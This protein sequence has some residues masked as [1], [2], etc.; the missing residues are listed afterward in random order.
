MTDEALFEFRPQAGFRLE[1]SLT[2]TGYADEDDNLDGDFDLM[3][4]LTDIEATMEN[5]EGEYP[6]HSNASLV[7]VRGGFGWREFHWSNEKVHRYEWIDCVF[8]SRCRRCESPDNNIFMVTDEVWRESGLDGWVCFRCV[9][10][11]LGRELVPTDFK[12]VPCNDPTCMR[13]VPELR[14]RMGHD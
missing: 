11:S 10:D 13:H 3:D 6:E 12:D 8:D 1:W 14:R 2:L 7:M 4:S 5:I 9:E